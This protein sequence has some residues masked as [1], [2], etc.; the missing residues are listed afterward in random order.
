MLL[1]IMDYLKQEHYDRSYISL[2]EESGVNLYNY[3]EQIDLLRKLILDGEW[4]E[5]EKFL[6]GVKQL[7]NFPYNSLLCQI[8]KEKIIEEIEIKQEQSEVEGLAQELQELQNL[9]MSSEFE[10]VINYLKNNDEYEDG[11]EN[12]K[13]NIISRRLNTF[14]VIREALLNYFPMNTNEQIVTPGKLIELLGKLLERFIIKQNVSNNYSSKLLTIQ[15]IDMLIQQQMQ[16]S[17]TQTNILSNNNFIN[18][19]IETD[20]RKNTIIHNN[21]NNTNPMNINN[22]YTYN[23]SI[24]QIN[25]NGLNR[26]TNTN[27]NKDNL[28]DLCDD[29]DIN[30][31][32]QNDNSNSNSMSNVNASSKIS[33]NIMQNNNNYDNDLAD[34]DQEEYYMKSCYDFYNYDIT[35]L[36]LKKVIEDTNPIRCCCFSP[37]GDYF[38]LGTNS[39]SIKIFDLSYILDNFNRRNSLIRNTYQQN[40]NPFNTNNKTLMNKETIGMIFEQ[41]EHHFGSIYSIDWCPSGKLIAT[42]SNDKTIKLL[43]I[44]SLDDSSQNVRELKITGLKG[45]VRSLCFEPTN[46]LQL[47]SASTN[48]ASVKL[49]NSEN[50][51]AISELKGHSDDVNVVK[52]SN[53]GMLFGSAGKDKRI[54]FWDIRESKSISILSGNRYLD[55]NDIS[56]YT[57]QTLG[58]APII[59]AGHK[60]GLITIWDYG[61]RSVIKEIYEHS[62]EVRSVSFSPDGKYLLSGSFDSKIKIFD[63]N[64]NFELMGEL[65]HTE[66]VVSCKWHPEIPLIISTSADKTARVWIPQK[67]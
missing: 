51:E 4:E 10:E 2:E 36:T 3:D 46:D 56:I 39:R 30:I 6:N 5:V 29:L 54:L 67:F 32:I 12:K 11:S 59:A 49:W 38:A 34:L 19:I 23:G 26:Q 16:L 45:V 44:P 20:P 53:D 18:E 9:G 65:E 21:N 33:Q 37:K 8:K 61:R 43:S 50:G 58:S 22:T 35:S 47:L 48:D 55:I 7:N 52:W 41:K 42:G 27:P 66:R 13:S 57:K 15:D 31:Q 63:V 40:V 14:N 28:D 24:N 25:M 17:Q 1:L 60:D 62:G 64:K